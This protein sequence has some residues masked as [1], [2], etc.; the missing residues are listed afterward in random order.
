[1]WC[2]GKHLSSSTILY[3]ITSIAYNYHTDIYPLFKNKHI[4][5]GHLAALLYVK[6]LE[7]RVAR[8]GQKGKSQE[9]S[10]SDRVR[11]DIDIDIAGDRSASSDTS[12]LDIGIGSVGENSN[13]ASVYRGCNENQERTTGIGIGRPGTVVKK[14][15]FFYPAIDPFDAALH[16]TVFSI[17]IPC[18]CAKYGQSLINWFFENIIMLG[19]KELWYSARPLEQMQELKMLKMSDIDSKGLQWPPCFI[20]HGELD[21][22]VPIE[23][24]HYFLS[25]L[26]K[27]FP[28]GEGEGQGSPN[29][30][31]NANTSPNSSTNVV[32]RE[33][34]V[35]LPM[36]GLRHSFE[37]TSADHVMKLYGVIMGWLDRND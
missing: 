17:P 26:A 33:E 30:N 7:A 28:T 27:H 3:N 31:T 11:G 34:D 19:K 18:L 24:S 29:A 6:I 35:F 4:A 22:I 14:F 32:M 1:M 25:F 16:N 10:S 21:S 23:A 15:V 20:A 36:P 12:L 5:G 8:V 37:N 2:I 13:N 9:K